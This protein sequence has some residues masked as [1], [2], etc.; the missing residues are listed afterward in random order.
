MGTDATNAGARRYR[1]LIPVVALAVVLALVSAAVIGLG[2]GR[3][4]DGVAAGAEPTPAVEPANTPSLRAADPTDTPT[5]T[6]TVGDA[7]EATVEV[8]VAAGGEASLPDGTSVWIP[9]GGVSQDTR[10]VL[11][12]A[13]SGAPDTADGLAAAGSPVWVEL[14]AGQLSDVAVLRLPTA[15]PQDWPADLTFDPWL[16][17]YDETT[18]EWI[19]H[20]GLYDPQ[21][22]LMVAQVEHFSWWNPFSWDYGAIRDS[23][24]QSLADAAG[25]PSGIP[26]EC[27]TSPPADQVTLTREG[28]PV[29]DSCL[30]LDGE[31][32]I[33]RLR[34]VKN[35][36]LLVA[37]SGQASLDA[38]TEYGLDVTSL[39]RWLTDQLGLTAEDSVVLPSGGDAHLQVSPDAT[40]PVLATASYDPKL[41]LIG[42]VDATTRVI[43][44]VRSATGVQTAAEEV[45]S[46]MSDSAC[47]G[48]HVDDLADDLV[49]ASTAI[50]AGCSGDV[51]ATLAKSSPRLLLR[52]AGM[53]PRLIASLVGVVGYAANA[54]L[55][56]FYT[57]FDV[58]A[59]T[60]TEQFTI[61]TPGSPTAPPDEPAQSPWP[62]R[63]NDGPTALW[64]WFGASFVL[65][66]WVSCDDQV[67]WCIAGIGREVHIIRL[68][69]LRDVGSV[70]LATTD[71]ATSLAGKG[72]PAAVI[73]ELL[74][75]D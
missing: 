59:G 60:T 66:D 20:T 51:L 3:P 52:V 36:P 40:A 47:L 10:L 19:P 33:L 34:G 15:P 31:R 35:Y 57:G 45:W 22:G 73:A 53:A 9:P 8:T 44:A 14:E 75:D 32:V 54:V 11:S 43:M 72:L 46:L 29:T 71:P 1:W 68:D 18:G 49:G 63:A 6:Q 39:Y 23:F 62:V 55:A 41:Q 30:D 27:S 24:V 48:Q 16:A 61:A 74:T 65:P 50:I 42:I 28:E 70:P 37:W 17:S 4:S 26:P 58:L 7:D 5:P 67:A 2:V 64:A 56:Q 25:A 38:R 12:R 13:R 69:G 21:T